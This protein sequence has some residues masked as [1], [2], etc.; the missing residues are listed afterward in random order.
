MIRSRMSFLWVTSSLVITEVAQCTVDTEETFLA[1]LGF[2]STVVHE[3]AE[4]DVRIE[5]TRRLTPA[6]CDV[7]AELGADQITHDQ[8]P[9]SSRYGGNGPNSSCH[10]RIVRPDRIS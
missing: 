4:L 2:D 3:V 1:I 8:A 10:R 7:G 9:A 5:R 6:E